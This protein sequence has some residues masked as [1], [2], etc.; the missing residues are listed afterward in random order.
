MA[1]MGRGR[2]LEKKTHEVWDLG[3]D[4]DVQDPD[5]VLVPTEVAQ[6]ERERGGWDAVWTQSRKGDGEVLK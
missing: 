3:G 6:A 2:G 4:H 1:G 5:A